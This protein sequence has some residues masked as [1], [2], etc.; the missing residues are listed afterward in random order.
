MTVKKVKF[1]TKTVMH[2][3]YINASRNTLL[4]ELNEGWNDYNIMTAFN[5]FYKDEGGKKRFVGEIKIGCAT[6]D[7]KGV[8]YDVYDGYKKYV[9]KDK[10]KGVELEKLRDF[11][12]S[13]DSFCSVGIKLEY[14]QELRALFDNEKEFEDF[15]DSMGDLIKKG[16]VE[17]IKKDEALF[18][19]VKTSLFR[20]ASAKSLYA[21]SKYYRKYEIKAY[22]YQ[23]DEFSK[24]LIPLKK[25]NASDEDYEELKNLLS[26]NSYRNKIASQMII[27]L[28]ENSVDLRKRQIQ[29]LLRYIASDNAFESGISLDAGKLLENSNEE[30]DK[31][32]DNIDH[33][34]SLLQVTHTDVKAL[35][36]GHYT[37][38][39][40]L[41]LLIRESHG[42]DIPTVR[43]TNS[44]QLND[45]SEGKILHQYI[46]DTMARNYKTPSV[47]ISSAT[48]ALDSLPMWK[49]YADDC[50]G[51]VMTYD[52]EFLQE[53]L[54]PSKST[55]NKLYQVCYIATD[56]IEDDDIK[57]EV[58]G[59]SDAD[60][61]KIKA[62]L[63]SLKKN[64]SNQLS[65][66]K[67]DDERE[68]VR[69]GIEKYLSDIEYL[70]KNIKYSYEQE[71]RIVRSLK[72]ESA[73]IV[74]ER[75]GNIPVPLLYA[76]LKTNDD[77]KIPVAYRSVC[78]GPMAIDID[79]VEPY[80]RFISNG[81][82]K[83]SKSTVD[84]REQYRSL[85]L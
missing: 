81:K 27:S 29:K 19:I 48:T 25:Y 3:E 42:E 77:R 50:K 20:D 57:I 59:R 36:L 71:Y 13:Y 75:S 79:Y 82:V 67:D 15:L 58:P 73:E 22:G 32:A 45:P 39:A 14:Y 66:V 61:Q 35:R 51:A 4:F 18:D 47:Y 85:K 8:I 33:L 53:I 64:I 70:F 84:F 37:S 38:L 54:K 80:V 69:D 17:E 12:G 56:E 34:K 26:I 76:Y 52:G 10:S 65:R 43:L 72:D 31:V 60:I 44:S 23:Q 63:K 41:P 11:T 6:D 24:L 16:D 5:A 9:A 21:L 28:D 7:L 49:Q 62:L 40:T 78:L 83:V 68:I 55:N 74:A 1:V 2:S 30:V 46:F